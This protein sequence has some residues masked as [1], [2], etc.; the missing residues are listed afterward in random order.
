MEGLEATEPMVGYSLI[1][2]NLDSHITWLSLVHPSILISVFFMH[3]MG[4]NTEGPFA[5]TEYLHDQED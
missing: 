1:R 4:S 5:I 3:L 2:A